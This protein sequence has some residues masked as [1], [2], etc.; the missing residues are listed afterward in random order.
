MTKKKTMNKNKK[1][2]TVTN[3]IQTTKNNPNKALETKIKIKKTK[4]NNHNPKNI[5]RSK[6]QP[7]SPNST[8]SLQSLNSNPFFQK[9]PVSAIQSTLSSTPYPP[10]AGQSPLIEPSK[11]NTTNTIL[12]A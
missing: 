5:P 6:T 10:T 9:S 8:P 2:K 3:K 7:D 4:N 1:M 11:V 12:K